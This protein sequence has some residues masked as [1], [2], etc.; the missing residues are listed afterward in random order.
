M[1]FTCEARTGKLV[2]GQYIVKDGSCSFATPCGA[3]AAEPL[4]ECCASCTAGCDPVAN[5]IREF[6]PP[7]RAG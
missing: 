6:H 4:R 1:L 3:A 7:R 5:R 2:S